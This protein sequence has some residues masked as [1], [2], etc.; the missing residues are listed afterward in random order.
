MD[1]KGDG[2]VAFW[3]NGWVLF[4]HVQWPWKSYSSNPCMEC[5][6]ICKECCVVFGHNVPHSY[7]CN[8]TAAHH[9]D[10]NH[11]PWPKHLVLC[12]MKQQIESGYWVPKNNINNWVYSRDILLF[13]FSKIKIHFFWM[14]QAVFM[15]CTVNMEYNLIPIKHSLNNVNL[16]SPLICDLFI[17]CL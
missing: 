16:C 11:D 10:N 3:Q 1:H 8:L 5:E 9:L 6:S 7:I 12:L 2:D 15:V 4:F 13:V 14:M 17:T